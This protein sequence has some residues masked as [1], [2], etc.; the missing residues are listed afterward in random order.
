[1]AHLSLF[2]LFAKFPD[3]KA[4]IR[5]LEEERWPEGKR[6]CLRCGSADN[7][8]DVPNCKPM[9]YRCGDCKRYFS[10]RTGSIMERSNLP[11]QKWLIAGFLLLTRPKGVSSVQLGKD[12]G[13]TQKTAWFL[14]HRLRTGIKGEIEMFKGPVEVD[15]AYLGGKEKNKHPHKRLHV[16]GGS[17]GKIPV[18]GVRDRPTGPM[19]YTFVIVGG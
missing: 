12:L 10:L 16:G 9:P 4:A 17:G 8:Q 5:W 2:E 7:V 19:A 18:M 13:I 1:M 11:L 3:E 6:S 15:E 14:G